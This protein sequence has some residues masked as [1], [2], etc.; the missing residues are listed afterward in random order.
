MAD[1][2]LDYTVNNS[3]PGKL[4]QVPISHEVGDKEVEVVGPQFMA[5]ARALGL[6]VHVWTVND[7]KGM[8][9]LIQDMGV[10]GIITDE[11]GLLHEVI[12]K[13]GCA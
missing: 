11:P 9:W 8:R 2:L 4:L 1:D 10:Q 3:K 7:P 13:L 6:K 12:R 5:K